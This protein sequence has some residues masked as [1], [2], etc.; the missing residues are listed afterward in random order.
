MVANPALAAVTLTL[1]IAMML[2]VAGAS[3]EIRIKA[4]AFLEKLNF[5]RFRQIVAKLVV[6][7]K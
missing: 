2:I 3:A 7:R 6:Q 1:L 5:E 4:V